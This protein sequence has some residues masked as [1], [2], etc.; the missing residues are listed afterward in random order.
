MIKKSV[1]NSTVMALLLSRKDFQMDSLEPTHSQQEGLGLLTLLMPSVEG[2]Q[3]E[4]PL[5]CLKP[6][7][8]HLSNARDPKQPKPTIAATILAFRLTLPFWRPAKELQEQSLLRLL[9][10]ANPAPAVV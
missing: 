1:P 7:S 4:E 2:K 6:F 8:G 3:L 9:S 5:T 10:I